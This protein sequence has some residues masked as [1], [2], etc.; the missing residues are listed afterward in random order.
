MLRHFLVFQRELLPPEHQGQQQPRQVRAAAGINAGTG[1]T[2]SAAGLVLFLQ[3]WS[4]GSELGE[5]FER[6]WVFFFILS[7]QC[8]GSD[9]L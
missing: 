3:G 5:T 6:N 1:A 4:W 9:S 7:V 8:F 2:A